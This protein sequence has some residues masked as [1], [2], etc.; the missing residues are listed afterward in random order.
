ME[1][2]DKDFKKAKENGSFIIKKSY[3][4]KLPD[5]ETVLNFV[6]N[7]TSDTE[8]E[9]GNRKVFEQILPELKII[10]TVME[11]LLFKTLYGLS[12]SLERYGK[13]LQN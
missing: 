12:Q 8:L 5:W 3:I 13:K 1:S 9:D 7:Q 6:Y 11:M 10:N 2:L 4:S